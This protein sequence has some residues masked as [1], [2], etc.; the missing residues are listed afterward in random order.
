MDSAL[1]YYDS[2]RREKLPANLIQ[3][4]RDIFGAHTYERI[5]KAGSY[6]TDWA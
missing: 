3:A 5:D 1:D 4:L 6:H 2:Y